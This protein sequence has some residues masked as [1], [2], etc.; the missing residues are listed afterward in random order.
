MWWWWL[1]KTGGCVTGTGPAWRIVP[2]NIHGA[3]LDGEKRILEENE[4]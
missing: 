4:N 3:R 2:N 1:G